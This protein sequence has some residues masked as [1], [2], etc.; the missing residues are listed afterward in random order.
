M[1]QRRFIWLACSC[2]ILFAP[3]VAVAGLGDMIRAATSIAAAKNAYSAEVQSLSNSAKSNGVSANVISKVMDLLKNNSQ[4]TY[5]ADEVAELQDKAKAAKDKE[6]STA[7]KMLGGL[8]M[9]ATGIGGM[10]LMQGLAEKQADE[11]AAKE[12]AA[13]LGTIACGVN[14]YK[15]VKY[16]EAGTTPELSREMGDAQLQ[17][18]V[19]AD[20]MKAAKEALGMPEGIES[21][22]IVDTAKLYSDRGTDTDGISHNF[23]T[24]TQR[25]DSGAGKK[26]AMIG[27]AVAG[28]GVVGGVVGNAVINGEKKG[29]ESGIGKL[30]G[31]SGIQNVGEGAKDVI[32][33]IG[34]KVDISSMASS[35]VGGN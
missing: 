4:K 20:K 7:N 11:T 12:M 29:G 34:S 14:G 13:Y 10:Q 26:R 3:V 24:A 31:S 2:A 25:A 35:V 5:S 32:S 18:A 27:G 8:T 17:Y 21:E 22:T 23:D 33:S 15:N 16:N 28:V 1:K 30:F 19:L 9:A 6:Q